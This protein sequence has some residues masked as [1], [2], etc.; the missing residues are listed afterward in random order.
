MVSVAVIKHFPKPTQ[1]RKW[2]FGQGNQGR[3]S[4]Q[5]PEERTKSQDHRRM[6]LFHGFYQGLL[7]F[8]S[9]TE[10]FL[11]RR[12]STPKSLGFPTS[13]LIK[14]KKKFNIVVQRPSD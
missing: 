4:N 2:L 10:D 5:E 6:Q 8:F 3:S 11:P 1:E 14:K 13:I 12:A 9:T 7:S